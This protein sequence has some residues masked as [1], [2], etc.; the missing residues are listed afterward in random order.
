[1][2]CHRRVTT[3]CSLHASCCP[4]SCVPL[5]VIAHHS[6]SC[7]DDGISTH[8]SVSPGHQAH[9]TRTSSRPTPSF[10]HVSGLHVPTPSTSTSPQQRR[11]WQRQQQQQQCRT[12]RRCRPLQPSLHRQRP[13][14]HSE[15]ARLGRRIRWCSRLV[16]VPT[17][18]T[19][20][21]TYIHRHILLHI[22]VC[23]AVELM[24]LD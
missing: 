18:S 13:Q 14:P 2:S 11:Y 22:R 7:C 23:G 4:A 12:Q 19:H 15:P 8:A 21:H 6:T 16:L 20:T 5:P 3:A 9:S 24:R 1:M 17:T 10:D